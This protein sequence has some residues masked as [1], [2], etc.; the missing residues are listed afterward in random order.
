MIF[1]DNIKY[2]RKLKKLNQ[3]QLSQKLAVTNTTISNW[4]N[5]VSAPDLQTALNISN[6]FG[7]SVND[8]FSCTLDGREIP[9]VNE[10]PV[11]YSSGGRCELCEQ[12]N[13]TIEV[14]KMLIKTQN[15]TVELLN[16]RNEDLESQLGQKKK[17]G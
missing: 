15:K 9:N 6:Y 5:G 17:A 10:P 13:E 1:S 14:L 7:I 3:I 11:N 2:L 16:T 8:L 4:E 12:K